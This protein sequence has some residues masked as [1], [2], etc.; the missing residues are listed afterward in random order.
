MLYI[1]ILILSIIFLIKINS[2]NLFVSAQIMQDHNKIESKNF[3]P[4]I[5]PSQSGGEQYKFNKSN[6]NDLIQVNET[7]DPAVFSKKNSD[8]SWKVD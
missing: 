2:I 7:E 3:I 6:P 4:Q 8:N 1:S 5:Y